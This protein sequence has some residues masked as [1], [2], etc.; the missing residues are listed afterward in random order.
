ME[1][2]DIDLKGIRWRGINKNEVFEAIRKAKPGNIK[3]NNGDDR[4]SYRFCSRKCDVN[5]ECSNNEEQ[6]R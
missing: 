3:C 6:L 1:Q 2:R 5:Y 4:S